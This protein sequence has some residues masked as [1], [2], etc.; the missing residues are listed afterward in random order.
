MPPLFVI[1]AKPR[2]VGDF[3]V[4]RSLPVVGLRHVGPFVFLDHMGP[5]ELAPG[6]GADVK[7]HPHIGLATVTY[8]FEGE[9][10][11]R[12][13][14]GFAQAIRP[15]DVNWM[16]AGKGIVHSERTTDERR[17]TGGALHGIQS[18]VALPER[19]EAREPSFE[20]HPASSLPRI[21]L[22]DARIDLVAGS[23]WGATS[24][25]TTLSP[26]VYAAAR[27]G[28]GATL[29][30]PEAEERAAYV[31][32]GSLEHQGMTHPEGTLV[33][34]DAG[35][36]TVTAATPALLMIL[37]GAHVGQRHIE[38]NFVASSKEAIEEAKRAWKERRFGLVPGDEDEFVPLP[39]R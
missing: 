6:T 20:H 18:W 12:D 9:S 16:I 31:V 30:L 1:S 39:E 11:H 34:F 13:S 7:P 29:E 35:P 27:L 24:P 15:G 22:P 36:E 21:E 23:A 37:G 2:S 33:V 10:F 38:W 25:V 14:L 17:R 26:T 3:T 19:E 8:L 32:H 4:R 28:A 5:V